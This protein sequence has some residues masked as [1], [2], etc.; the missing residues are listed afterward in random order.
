[1]ARALFYLLPSLV[2]RELKENEKSSYRY[3]SGARNG[4]LLCPHAILPLD[5]DNNVLQ[6][7]A[8]QNENWAYSNIGFYT[9]LASTFFSSL[10]FPTPSL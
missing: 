3:L 4:A 8:L 9:P 6:V 7:A 1:M 10:S 5:M 2:E